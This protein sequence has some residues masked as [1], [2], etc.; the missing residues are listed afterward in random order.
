MPVL[1]NPKHEIA[2]KSIARGFT[3]RKAFIEAGLQHDNTTSVTTRPE[4]RARVAELLEEKDRRDREA[5]ETK[6]Q[7]VLNNQYGVDNPVKLEEITIEYIVNKLIDNAAKSTESKQFAASNKAYQLVGEIL[8]LF[9]HG[10]GPSEEEKKKQEAEAARQA[11]SLTLDQVSKA[12]EKTGFTG[13]IDLTGVPQGE[14]M[15]PLKRKS[16]DT[17]KEEDNEENEC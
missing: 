2:A 17:N 8:G 5:E 6:K 7:V 15:K 9:D 13:V 4:F 1:L 12:L 11:Q 16:V 14:L 3:A 10:K